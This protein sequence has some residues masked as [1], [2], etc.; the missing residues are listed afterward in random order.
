[1]VPVTTI[2]TEVLSGDH[3]RLA[4]RP[5]Q[6]FWWAGRAPPNLGEELARRA[7]PRP[8]GVYAHPAPRQ[9]EVRALACFSPQM[10]EELSSSVS[11]HFVGAFRASTG[12]RVTAAVARRPRM[13]AYGNQ[14]AVP[15]T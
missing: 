7:L 12:R 6:F 9:S 8:S 15:R 11:G 10:V 1:M 14:K 2:C 13:L 4:Q 3:G 5:K